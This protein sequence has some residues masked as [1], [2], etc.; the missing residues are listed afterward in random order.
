MSE[1]D[2]RDA[3][4]HLEERRQWAVSLEAH[5]IKTQQ[6]LP[7]DESQHMVVQAHAIR[8]RYDRT[9][10]TIGNLIRFYQEHQHAEKAVPV[11]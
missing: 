8:E 10:A 7:S 2:L 1:D 5:M 6:S 11:P 9:L 3:I 4:V